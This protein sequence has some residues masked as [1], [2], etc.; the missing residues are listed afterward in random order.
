MTKVNIKAAIRKAI[1]DSGRQNKE[2]AASIGISPQSLSNYAN[3]PK[4]EVP[5]NILRSL[6]IELDDLN[7]KYVASDWT[8]ELGLAE[9][10]AA[11]IPIPI[12]L[13]E[14]VDDEQDDREQLDRQAKRVF[15]KTPE[16]WSAEDYQL[17]IRYRKE[18]NEEIS[19]EHRMLDAVDD[20]LKRA[21]AVL[22]EVN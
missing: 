11:V 4:R 21:H 13:K 2:I 12:A 22:K 14:D 18:F 8:F 19:A 9:S 7:F 1:A 15:K 17:I 3:D 16:S 6:V 5:L 20:S 10:G